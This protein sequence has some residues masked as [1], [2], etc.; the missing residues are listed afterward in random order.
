MAIRTYIVDL[1]K[2]EKESIREYSERMYEE[3]KEFKK[4]RPRI[5]KPY[6]QQ[7][8]RAGRGAGYIINTEYGELPATNI[9]NWT[10]K[11]EQEDKEKNMPLC[12]N[13]IKD[14]GLCRTGCSEEKVIKLNECIFSPE[15]QYH[16][17][18]YR[19]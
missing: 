3:N 16:C 5:G 6:S 13:F 2:S 11:I 10:N 15:S 4:A 1:N 12:R 14:R 8:R 19:K 7:K 17:S 18:C 9:E